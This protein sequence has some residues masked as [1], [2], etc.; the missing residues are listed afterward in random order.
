MIGCLTASFPRR[1]RQHFKSQGLEHMYLNSMSFIDRCQRV[2]VEA[3]GPATFNRAYTVHDAIISYLQGL[4]NLYTS[5]R[6]AAMLYI[7]E[8]LSIVI[9]MGLN[10]TEKA[11]DAQNGVPAVSTSANG[12]HLDGERP[13]PIDLVIQELDKR[14]FWIIFVGVRSLQ[15]LGVSP[16][17]LNIPPP[18]RSDPYPPLP[19]EIDDAYLTPTHMMQQP[20]GHTPELFGFNMSVKLYLTYSSVALNELSYGVDELVDWKR[21]QSEL[22]QSLD[23]IRRILES[24]PPSLFHAQAQSSNAAIRGQEYSGLGASSMAP[25]D[26]QSTA[27]ITTVEERVQMQQD[28]QRVSIYANQLGTRSWLVRKFFALSQAHT[29]TL[30]VHTDTLN[31]TA[32]TEY[33]SIIMSFYQ[34]LSSLQRI[35]LE[36]N[37]AA[38]IPKIHA[39]AS[40]LLSI[41]L[42]QESPPTS[43]SKDYLRK[44]LN[45]L[46][47]L[48]NVARANE[49]RNE[50]DEESK[51]RAWADFREVQAQL[52]SEGR[53]PNQG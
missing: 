18:T 9:T 20:D 34:M 15:Q 50:E 21:Q 1:P 3:H 11:Q 36:S 23:S 33:N 45:A 27:V 31:A 7:K 16:F 24:L 14:I 41:P 38:V 19:L 30:E 17:E 39:V 28:V 25:L 44:V 40:T 5:Q 6:Q 52:V 43:I 29:K 46:S 51:S 2:A 8:A 22:E 4:A 12:H 49:A 26:S 42:R 48:E 10:K 35:H 37:G 47:T 53:I 32:S 13:P